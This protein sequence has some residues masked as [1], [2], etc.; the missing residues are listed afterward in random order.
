[1]NPTEPGSN[2]VLGHAKR[3]WPCV[4]DQESRRQNVKCAR[5]LLKI[6]IHLGSIHAMHPNRVRMRLTDIP[7]AIDPV[8]ATKGHVGKTLKCQIF[9]G[10]H[11]TRPNSSPAQFVG[12][13]LGFVAWVPQKIGMCAGYCNYPGRACIIAH[14]S[15]KTACEPFLFRMNWI[16]KAILNFKLNKL[17]QMMLDINWTLAWIK[18]WT[19]LLTH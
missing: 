16:L 14:V 18:Y 6:C 2:E 11:A 7:S 5:I 13:W 1:M 9:C 17:H 4:S 12:C 3:G 15:V 8:Y 19:E 10:T